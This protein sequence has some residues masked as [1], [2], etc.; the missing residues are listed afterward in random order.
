M[1]DGCAGIALIDGAGVG[2]GGEGD[3]VVAGAH[4][5]IVAVVGG[6]DASPSGRHGAGDGETKDLLSLGE[7]VIGDDEASAV[8]GFAAAEIQGLAVIAENVI[9]AA[10]GGAAADGEGQSGT[11]GRVGEGDDEGDFVALI[12]G[13]RAAGEGD[14]VVVGGDGDGVGAL[15]AESP[16]GGG[17]GGKGDGDGFIGFGSGI[18][19]DGDAQGG[20]GGGDAGG[21][22]AGVG[23]VAAGHADGKT[24]AGDAAG[25]S[26]GQ[27]GVTAALGGGGGAGG[28]E[29]D[30]VVVGGDGDGVGAL[31]AEGP[32]GG[33][34]GGEGDGDGFCGFGGGIVVDGDAQ[35]VAGD[36][37]RQ[38]AGVAGVAAGH[39]H[40]QTA[41]G[42][43]A[44]DGEGDAGG[45]AFIGG[46]GAGGAEGDAVVT[47]GDGE[48][49]SGRGD[50]PAAG[51]EVA[52][53]GQAQADD[54]RGFGG[55]VL[56]GEGGE[57]SAGGRGGEGESGR[58]HAGIG[59]GGGGTAA[60]PD[61]GGDIDAEAGGDGAGSADGEVGVGAFLDFGRTAAGK[62]DVGSVVIGDGDAVLLGAIAGDGAP[63]GGEA[64]G[65][66]GD[67]EHDG[68]AIG[69]GVLGDGDAD[70][71]GLGA[72]GEGLAGAESA[73]GIAAVVADGH[74][75]AAAGGV[76]GDGDD[77]RDAAALGC[78]AGQGRRLAELHQIVAGGDGDAMGA[79][80]AE[81]PTGGGHASEGDGD[82]FI[83]FGGVVVD[84]GDGEGGGVLG[85][86]GGQGASVGG[87]AAGHADGETAAGDAAVDAQGQGGV[88]TALGDAG[89]GAGEG[90]G[91][92]IGGDGDGVGGVA[93]ESPTGGGDAGEGD[94]DIL[95][96]FGSGILADLN[97]Q[98]GVVV[99]IEA[100]RQGAGV[101]GV[102]AGHSDFHAAGGDAALGGEGDAGGVTLIGG[103]C[104]AGS[105]EFDAVIIG[106]NDDAVGALAAESPA[107]GG[108]RGE[109]DG[110]GF[111]AF[112][113]GVGIDGDGEGGG[114]LGDAGGQGAGVA[115]VAAGH[116]YGKTAAGD[117][118]AD[119]EGDGDIAALGCGAGGAGGH[120]GDAAVIGRHD[121]IIGGGGWQRA[122]G[123]GDAA[124]QGE[125]DGLLGFR[126]GVVGD[127]EAAGQTGG[128]AG[129]AQGLAVGALDVIAAA[130]GG[131]AG[132][133]E[134][135]VAAGRRVAQDDGE[136]HLVALVGGCSVG[137]ESDA[138]VIGGDGEAMGALAA[139]SPASGGHAGEGDGD[140]FIGFG[141]VVIGGGDD[142][143]GGG[144]AGGQGAGVGGAAAGHADGKTAGGDAAAA[145]QGQGDG[146]A[147]PFGNRSGGAGAG[148]AD[149]VVIG[150]DGDGVG[151]VAA[152]SPAGGGYGGEGDG[153]GFLPF[154][155]GV[156]ADGDGQGGAGDAGGQGDIGA[157]DAG[158]GGGQAHGQAANRDAAVG[159]EG[160]AGAAALAD[161]AGTAGSG[162][163]DGVVVGGDGDGEGVRHQRPIAG[164]V[165]GSQ[166]EDDGFIGFGSGV[167]IHGQGDGLGSCVTG[168]ERHAG[169]GQGVVIAGTGGGGASG[170]DG[171][172]NAAGGNS[173]DG[174]EGQG[175]I[176]AAAA[177]FCDF[178]AAGTE[179]DGLVAQGELMADAA[180]VV[181]ETP[182]NGQA[183]GSGGDGDGHR[184]PGCADILHGV[185]GEGNGGGGGTGADGRDRSGDAGIAGSRGQREIFGDGAV[186]IQGKAAAGSARTE[187][188]T[189]GSEG[190]LI[191]A[192]DENKDERVR[193]H[194]PTGRK[195]CASTKDNSQFS[196]RVGNSVIGNGNA[197][198]HFLGAGGDA[199]GLVGGCRGAGGKTALPCRTCANG[200]GR[201]GNFGAAGAG[202]GGH[203]QR[204]TAGGDDIVRRKVD[205]NFLAFPDVR[206]V[207][208]ADGLEVAVGDAGD[209]DRWIAAAA[210]ADGQSLGATGSDKTVGGG[211]QA[212]GDGNDFIRL[213]HPVCVDCDGQGDF[214]L[215]GSDG[216]LATVFCACAA[217]RCDGRGD[218]RRRV[219]AAARRGDFIGKSVISAGTKVRR[220]AAHI[221]KHGDILVQG[222][223][224]GDGGLDGVTGADAARPELRR[225]PRRL[226][227][228]G[229]LHRNGGKPLLIQDALLP[230][231][232]APQVGCAH[233]GNAIAAN[234]F[235]AGQG[236]A[237][238]KAGIP[239]GT[240]G[241]VAVMALIAALEENSRAHLIAQ[242]QLIGRTPARRFIPLPFES[243]HAQG[244]IQAHPLKSRAEAQIQPLQ[245]ALLIAVAPVPPIAQRVVIV[246]AAMEHAA[247][248][249]RAQ[250]KPLV[251]AFKI[252]VVEQGDAGNR[253][254]MHPLAIHQPQIGID[255]I[256]ALQAGPDGKPRLQEQH[257]AVVAAHAAQPEAGIPLPQRHN[258]IQ[259]AAQTLAP[260]PAQARVDG[261]IAAKQGNTALMHGIFQSVEKQGAGGRTNRLLA[262]FVVGGGAPAGGDGVILQG[263]GDG[264]LVIVALGT[265][266]NA[267]PDA[268]QP[269]RGAGEQHIIH[270]LRRG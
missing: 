80:A 182:T 268:F 12:G 52:A 239:A 209:G 227:F 142:E 112:G 27:V 219:I 16:A 42:K 20:G 15:A 110:D 194:R 77:Q 17:Y 54:F 35:T 9:A 3:G 119:I 29:G 91:I 189:G 28:H 2:G 257:P 259:L 165:G 10:G 160:N 202:V 120:E 228:P 14:G 181:G 118:A 220:A 270:R 24:A 65:G 171:D 62:A 51:R 250:A 260:D 177:R 37:G 121:D 8:S 149:G 231:H 79:L 82:G 131:A 216:N 68:F 26:Q 174:A 191:V 55:G 244:A 193:I 200:N 89:R 139:E 147:L 229:Q 175:H 167:V 71:D 19:H 222:R 66:G 183:T 113:G 116:G 67:G 201:N 11:G 154:G 225:R 238:G 204:Q 248:D 41:G 241:I 96:G 196:L 101:A 186:Q 122:P 133:G 236:I 157:G 126:G 43:G 166:I 155:D 32:A 210:G 234:A 224:E 168:V 230:L 213:G 255:A 111:F 151:G 226:E 158:A 173:D 127:G 106:G 105:A 63:G 36:A 179:Q 152:E 192:G 161:G 212:G 221:Q 150:G 87:V 208:A 40:G 187:D 22:G 245:G 132:D 163:A 95:I 74:R 205:E 265:A 178:G 60:T 25:D 214:G 261:E 30:A 13:G 246:D 262:A 249:V 86:G 215:A 206:L 94:G 123:G 38:G 242:I 211:L 146:D 70:I 180:G 56:V 99:G 107:G 128:V 254:H 266:G 85:D 109:G 252:M 156:I 114:V 197:D 69:V 138:V 53:F 140:A 169:P 57:G 50:I 153:D 98:G 170:G 93:A 103:G 159:G 104:A 129:E 73:D 72:A 84:D 64:G 4:G 125:A 176:G 263:G 141:S 199:D 145:A 217:G 185:V 188:G 59:G 258:G 247:L 83:G 130:G 195:I 233:G 137:G 90:D 39:A 97:V 264:F 203:R 243:P 134:G 78:G 100:G 135:Q 124:G 31:A 240:E 235:Q 269:G 45:I 49:M 232:G 23:G 143:G 172:G 34:Y 108:H 190:N 102:A 44:G 115:G 267:A 148:E 6:V 253:I 164:Q 1:G 46:G 223:T 136:G 251:S 18:I 21:Q 207:A 198:A 92:V 61:L 256:V 33:G 48:F 47:G 184:Q 7:G 117:G 88:G 144:D 75:H 237:E 5:Y 81:S 76:I 162:E 218:Q 58:V